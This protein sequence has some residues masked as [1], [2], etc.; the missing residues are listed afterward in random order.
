MSEMKRS[1]RVWVAGAPILAV[2]TVA[3]L[4]TGPLSAQEATVRAYLE[5]AEVEVGERFRVIVEVAGVRKVEDVFIPPIFPASGLPGDRL[6]PFTTEIT[7]PEPG[8]TGG[9]VVFAYSFAAKTAG[10]VEIGPVLVTADG[11]DLETVLPALSVKDP[12]AVAVQAWIEPAEVRVMEEFELHVHVAGV[13][14]LLE[15][16]V[17]PDMSAFARRSGRGVGGG[18]ARFDFVALQSGTREIGP[19]SVR[20][21]NNVY[22]SEPLTLV[23]SDEPPAVEA[24]AFLNTEQAWAGGDFMLLL[25]VGPARELDEEPVLPDLSG[26]A[27]LVRGG[28]SGGAFGVLPSG[29][30]GPSVRGEY[31]FRALTAGEFEIGPVRLR[32][33]GRTIHTEPVH[34]TIGE[35]LPEPVVS[36]EDL[37]LATEADR[38]RT[39]VG[40]PV[41]VSYRILSRESIWLGDGAWRVEDYGEPSSPFESHSLTLP[42]QEDF[43]AR[44]V[45]LH[46][47][48]WE[49]IWLDGRR[50]EP[51]GGTSVAYFP[52]EPGDKTIAPAELNVQIHR[53]GGWV[54]ESGPG[55]LVAYMIA[56]RRNWVGSWIPVALTADPVSIKVVPLPD[57]GRPESFRGHVGRLGL[58]AWVDRTDAAVGDTLTLLIE[59]A[60]DGH[61]EFIPQPEIMFPEGF[62]VLEVE[63]SQSSRALGESLRGTRHYTYRLV[64]NHEG[65]Y[66]IPAMELSWFDSESATYGTSRAGPF[67]ITVASSAMEQGR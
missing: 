30:S 34:I 40:E 45:R 48:S 5:P 4:A 57:E 29:G 9:V 18:T 24:Y 8:R 46:G 10:S 33:G 39:Y 61:S 31:Q 64:A 1:M 50:Y 17:L 21:G 51:A 13:E 27:E 56:S 66:R 19:V 11:H 54:R 14:S 26:F 12:T 44:E 7:G 20:V 62:E 25:E 23:V 60:G 43:H 67:D 42:P 6:L 58:V 35:T 3:L 32:V 55:D 52:L 65:S 16:P 22:E 28:A 2:A 36:P 49:S 41:V 53:R 38:E 15:Q 37:R 59:L 63:T 47:G